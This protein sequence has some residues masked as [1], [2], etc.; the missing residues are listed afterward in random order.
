VELQLDELLIRWSVRLAIACYFGR[1]IIDVG[2]FRRVC[3]NTTTAVVRRLWTIGCLLYLLHVL[4][5]F[6]FVHH[7]SHEQALVHTVQQTANITGIPWEGGIYVNYAFTLFWLG[8]TIAWWLRGTRTHYRS[9][10][11]FVMV[12]SV[13]AFIVFNATII[14]GPPFWDWVV[15]V[16]VLITL[17]LCFI[18]LMRLANDN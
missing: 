17:I 5:A 11:Y 9:M 12:H 4:C 2:R 7:W 1:V 14:F 10:N 6:A 15:L 18:H 3:K 16:A 8:D 13:F